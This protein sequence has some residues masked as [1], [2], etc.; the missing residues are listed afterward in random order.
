MPDIVEFSLSNVLFDDGIAAIDLRAL[1]VDVA[2]TDGGDMILAVL[3][4]HAIGDAFARVDH[5]RT[6]SICWR[7]L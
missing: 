3:E 1:R 5:Q 7:L 2:M 4:E 6:T